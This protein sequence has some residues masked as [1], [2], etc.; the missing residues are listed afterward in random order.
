MKY[1]NIML[2]FI[3]ISIIAEIMHLSPIW[4]FIL[5]ALAIIP[6]A[7]YIGRS[8]EAISV[9][10]GDRIGGFL[11]ATLGNATELIISI[12]AIK[13][14][15]FAVVKASIAGSI[16]GNILLVLG[17]S[18][19]A[20]GI[21]FNIQTFNKK[22]IEVTSTMLLFSIIAITVPAFFEELPSKNLL[23]NTEK[24]SIV[25]SIIL[26]LIYIATIVFSM[27][28]HK[29][30]YVEESV[31]EEREEIEGGK[32]HWP[33]WV[34]LLV[35]IIVTIFIAIES[36]ILVSAVEPMTK[37]IG[38]SESFVGLILIPIIGNAAEHS[39]AVIMA[40][41]DKMNV[42]MEIA[43]GS[44][45]QIILFVTPIL[46]FVSLFFKPM[47][48]IFDNFELIALISAVIIANKVSIDGESNWL[49]GLVLIGIYFILAVMFFFF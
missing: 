16:L 14:G 42:A 22:A 21:K 1:L 36:E 33:L 9:Y 10:T 27:I 43:I 24:I 49:E 5:S 19:L 11:N 13:E 44:S 32:K 28:T 35:L 17:A 40:I 30:L 41:K 48:I 37:I 15:L 47:S 29:D 23:V 2:I 4:I 12:L 18:M 7:A 25:I 8:T 26:F 39:T 34:A 46:V 45:L 3:P 6:L 38:I 31:A 20:G